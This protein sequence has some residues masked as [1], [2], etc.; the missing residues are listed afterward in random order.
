MKNKPKMVDGYWWILHVD[1]DA[2]D[3]S[4]VEKYAANNEFRP[5]DEKHIT[6]VGSKCRDAIVEKMETLDDKGKQ[7][8]LEDIE[9]LMNKYDWEFKAKE[10][11]HIKKVH[12]G[13]EKEAIICLIDMQSLTSFY[14]EINSLLNTHLPV[15]FPHISLFTKGPKNKDGY[16][17]IPLPSEES[18]KGS[19]YKELS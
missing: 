15:Q 17:G 18:F 19:T 9:A 6:I 13:A 1:N 7:K 14:G 12:E 16:Y 10:Y 11:F 4:S 5:K 3:I 8:L 2:V